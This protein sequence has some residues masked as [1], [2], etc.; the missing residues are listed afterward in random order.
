MTVTI[1]TPSVAS[2]DWPTLTGRQEP[3]HLHYTPGDTRLGER[4]ADMARRL[5]SKPMPWQTDMVTY[6]NSVDEDDQWTHSDGVVIC[7]RQNGKSEIMVMLILHRLF[8]MNQKIIFTAHE[9][10]TAED[11][12]RRLEGL[13][14]RSKKLQRRIV[15]QRCSQGRGEMFLTSGAQVTFTTRSANAGRG[16]SK[17]DLLIYDEAFNLSESE[18]SAL[19]FT[20]SASDNPQ[21]LYTSSAV[22]AWMHPDGEVLSALRRRGLAG[23]DPLMFFAEFCAPEDADRGAPETWRLANPSYGALMTEKKVLK[24][25]RGMNTEQG[26]IAFDVEALGRGVW[27]EEAS[28]EDFVPVISEEVRQGAVDPAPYPAG[29]SV[30]AL[31]AS[32][33][34]E[35]LSIAAGVKTATGFHGTLG[36]HDSFD[37]DEAVSYVKAILDKN[38]NAETVLIDPKSPANTLIVPLERA[39]V[40]VT[41][42][43]MPQHK[44]AYAS[45]LS[46]LSERKW[47]LDDDPRI[48]EQLSYAKARE[49]D[50][51]AMWDRYSGDISS[52]V[53]LSFALWGA[54]ALEPEKKPERTAPVAMAVVEAA[55]VG[56]MQDFSF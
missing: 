9:W 48:V 38:D 53:A 11:L 13:V 3:E 24:L 20:Q 41:K 52:L 28:D 23:D 32:P 54:E 25:M 51:G 35:F 46:R 16:L 14:A 12:Y 39:D 36:Y 49:K 29:H 44:Q 8:E 4:A 55:D 21:T 34:G 17:I 2:E 30:L 5:G 27:H 10:K 37:T 18:I 19:S 56:M 6:I 7:P 43:N 1:Q 31:D 22:N 47:S 26:R 50:G 45:F 40:E 42:V 15:K 33:D